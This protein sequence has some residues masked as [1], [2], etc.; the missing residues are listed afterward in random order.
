M[1]PVHPF[2]H[3]PLVRPLGSGLE[4]LAFRPMDMERTQD[5]FR[6]HFTVQ[7]RNDRN[8]SAKNEEERKPTNKRVSTTKRERR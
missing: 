2:R 4:D 3:H 6:A 8:A 7:P 5:G 1:A